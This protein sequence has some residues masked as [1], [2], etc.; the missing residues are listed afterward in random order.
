[1]EIPLTLKDINSLSSDLLQKIALDLRYDEIQKW[2]RTSKRFKLVICDNGRFWR[3]K[4]IQDFPKEQDKLYDI[5]LD[6]ME[7]IYLFLLSLL[8]AED[9]W[10]ARYKL[11]LLHKK[12]WKKNTTLLR[13]TYADAMEKL[14][15][16]SENNEVGALEI[17]AIEYRYQATRNNRLS[18]EII[19]RFEP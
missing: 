9:A 15:L 12:G 5:P 19:K 13:M 10:E 3:T 4:I 1:M 18:P 6:K 17:K 11:N 8:I 7:S 16:A 2:C 14:G